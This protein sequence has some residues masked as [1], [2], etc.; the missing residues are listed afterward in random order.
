MIDC[1]NQFFSVLGK[2]RMLVKLFGRKFRRQFLNSLFKRELLKLGARL[3]RSKN[4]APT[5]YCLWQTQ[6]ISPCF[7]REPQS[8]M[9]PRLSNQGWLPDLSGA[10]LSKGPHPGDS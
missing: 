2:T 9:T 5:V 8:G 6:S 4:P 3:N 10:N 7:S 1:A